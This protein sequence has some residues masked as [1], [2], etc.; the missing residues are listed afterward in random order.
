M[1]N[2][3]DDDDDDRRVDLGISVGVYVFGADHS[4]HA[5]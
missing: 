2:Y 4:G 5:V 1:S 3:D